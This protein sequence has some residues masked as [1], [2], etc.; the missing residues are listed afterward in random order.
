M[1]LDTLQDFPVIEELIGKD[2]CLSKLK[3][4]SEHPLIS[5]L[6]KGTPDCQKITSLVKKYY[7][8]PDERKGC[9]LFII[10]QLQCYYFYLNHLEQS[11][12]ILKDEFKIQRIINH[13]KNE[14]QFW[15][16][17]AEAEIAALLK[18]KFQGIELE[19]SLPNGRCV[20]VKFKINK[21]WIFAE[22]TVPR[23]GQKYREEMEK[24]KAREEF[25]ELPDSAYRARRIIH[26]EAEHFRNLDDNVPSIIF[27]NTNHSEINKSEI[28]D[29]LTGHDKFVIKTNQETKEFNISWERPSWT[30]FREDERI[31][32]IGAIISYNRNFTLLGNVVYEAKFFKI[33]FTKK[34]IESLST[35]FYKQGS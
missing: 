12:K 10:N 15:S 24:D 20:D 29:A 19:P 33:N 23:I 31:K 17:Y 18:S 9:V 30:V 13:L 34:D 25:I 26:K 14:D 11:L 16:G 6:L 22:V 3:D 27:F 8:V 2:W 35:M 7:E 28:E 5:H 21:K 32:Q 4:G 1:V